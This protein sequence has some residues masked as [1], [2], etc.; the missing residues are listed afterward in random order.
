MTKQDFRSGVADSTAVSVS[1]IV[2]LR[3][4][5]RLK[6]LGESKI[7]Y[8]DMSIHVDNYVFWFKISIYYVLGVHYLQGQKDFCSIEFHPVF[9]ILL[10]Q[11]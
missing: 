8:F 1:F 6:L 4:S 3:I 7:N 2:M 5:G 10:P 9:F 11:E